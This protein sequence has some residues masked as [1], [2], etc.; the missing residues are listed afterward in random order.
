MDFDQTLEVHFYI[1]VAEKYSKEIHLNIRGGNLLFYFV[2]IGPV[3]NK[4]TRFI[5]F[6]QR[7]NGLESGD[8]YIYI[9]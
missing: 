9:M 8:N 7:S 3:I 1:T 6:L 2:K 5:I 4:S